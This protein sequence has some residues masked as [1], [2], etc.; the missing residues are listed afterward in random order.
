M[1][2]N[3]GIFSELNIFTFYYL[4]LVDLSSDGLLF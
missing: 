1:H 4:A 3:N 2:L